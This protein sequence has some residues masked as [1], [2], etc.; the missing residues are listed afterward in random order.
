MKVKLI[1]ITQN[2]IDV[3]W[4]AA[5]T[6][7][8]SESP[9]DMWE[10]KWG[11]L[12]PGCDY[13]EDG[14]ER[15]QKKHWKLVK[16]VLGSRHDSIAEHVYFT[17]A[18]EG[19]SRSCSHQLT[20]HRAGIVFCLDEDT[21]I[22]RYNPNG[23][24]DYTIKQLYERWNSKRYNHSM[25]K[26]ELRSVSKDGIIIPNYIENIIDCGYQ[27]VYN[28]KTSLGYSLNCTMNH[29]LFNKQGSIPLKNLKIGDKILINGLELYKDKEWFIQ[30][31]CYE[32]LNTRQ[33]AA[34]CGIKPI[35]ADVWKRK[36]GIKNDNSFKKR[37][38]TEQTRLKIS[39]ANKG[40]VVSKETKKLLS[41]QKLGNLNPQFKPLRDVREGQLRKEHRKAK[42]QK[43]QLCGCQ[44]VKLHIH[45]ID[46]NIKNTHP[47]NALTL[48]PACHALV[49]GKKRTKKIIEDVITEINYVGKKQ[50]YD[51]EM[52]APYHNFIA[53]GILVHNSQQSQRYV[54]IKEDYNDIQSHQVKYNVADG[55]E[56]YKD[57][58]EH[59]TA[60]K[61]ICDKYFVD[62]NED[63]FRTFANMLVRYLMDIEVGE[64]PEDARQLLPN[65]TKTNITMSCNLRELIHICNL[66]LCSRAQAEIRELFKLIKAEVTEQDERL[67]SLLVPQCESLGY[68]PEHQCCGKMK[69]LPELLGQIRS[70]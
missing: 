69:T 53:N 34:L 3:M 8:A 21:K 6:C 59:Y 24:I 25:K 67:G 32:H 37:E 17:F 39:E 22:Y 31:Y 50:T 64:K 48:C 65:A 28:I 4:T 60:L 9:I 51:I 68:C 58:K 1:Q 57:M 7:Y 13:S 46:K 70:N 66:R 44:D 49:H 29:V 18:I 52:R 54:E 10:N 38:F 35:T 27:T 23:R 45:H 41:K 61:Q 11:E 56:D 63:N 30:K 2:P 14:I 15:K 55:I 62:V 33:I 47:S 26:L 40:R 36:H 19:I 20:R 5:R 12:S 43:C 42:L 16:K